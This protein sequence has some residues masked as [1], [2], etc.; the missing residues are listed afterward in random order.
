MVLHAPSLHFHIGAWFVTA[1]CTMLAFWMNLFQKRNIIDFEKRLGDNLISRLD[2]TAHV[3]GLVGLGGILGSAYLGLLDAS[4]VEFHLS[5]TNYQ[6]ALDSIL[7]FLD[8]SVVQQGFEN[9]LD[10]SLLGYKVVWTVVGVQLFLI[11]G[12]IRFYF[13]TIRKNKIY[14]THI[15]VQV[16]YSGAASWGF[17]VMVAISAAGGIYSYNESVMENIPI[18]SSLLPGAEFSLLPILSIF[19]GF[20]ALMMI[21]STFVWKKEK[22]ESN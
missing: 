2:F 10:N 11:S 1:V 22:S 6:D 8:F 13:V 20:L 18:L 5:L 3:C 14:D 16:I 19:F 4:G 21:L 15:G 7:F 12:I 9:A 17:V